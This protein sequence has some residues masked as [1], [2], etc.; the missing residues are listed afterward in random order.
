MVNEYGGNI[1][2]IFPVVILAEKLKGIFSLLPLC[3]RIDSS[4]DE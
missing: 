4:I 1:P 3:F 2:K